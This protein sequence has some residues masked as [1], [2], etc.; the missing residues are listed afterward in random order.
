MNSDK[1]EREC[2][3]PVWVNP[4]T[5]EMLSTE[6]EQDSK[7]SVFGKGR[8]SKVFYLGV[9]INVRVPPV[10]SLPDAESPVGLFVLYWTAYYS[11]EYGPSALCHIV[12]NGDFDVSAIAKAFGGKGNCDLAEFE[13][14]IETLVNWMI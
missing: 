10:R 4:M 12:S 13:V 9:S 6:P 8:F 7:A 2:E 1:L 3:I 11:R 14:P 5:G